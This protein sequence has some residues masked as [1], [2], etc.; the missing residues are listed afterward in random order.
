M[1]KVE[2]K[3]RGTKAIGMFCLPKVMTVLKTAPFGIPMFQIISVRPY[4]YHVIHSDQPHVW[5]IAKNAVDIY[6]N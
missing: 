4:Y 5:R 6:E 1:K 3:P 2:N